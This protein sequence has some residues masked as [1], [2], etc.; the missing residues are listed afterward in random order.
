MFKFYI[1]VRKVRNN[2]QAKQLP[3]RLREQGIPH[4]FMERL[5]INAVASCNLMF[6]FIQTFLEKYTPASDVSQALGLMA[7]CLALAL[8]SKARPSLVNISPSSRRALH[9]GLHSDSPGGS[10]CRDI[11]QIELT[12]KSR[13]FISFHATEEAISSEFCWHL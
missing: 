6:I 7:K 12:R 9:K 13:I 11:N 3:R 1:L 5:Q 10:S 2:G 8:S 4:C